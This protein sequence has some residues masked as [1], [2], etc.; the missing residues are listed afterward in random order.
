MSMSS[1]PSASPMWSNPA[2]V[3]S[4]LP[5]SG[6]S[7]TG[8]PVAS[9]PPKE[10]VKETVV[11]FEGLEITLDMAKVD[12]YYFWQFR[13]P[14]FL[15]KSPATFRVLPHFFFSGAGNTSKF[16]GGIRKT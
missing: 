4:S 13:A 8:M 1:S 3:T 16:C 11:D 2:Y 5:P 6:L 15:Q 10:E 9:G 14:P 7:V 12:T